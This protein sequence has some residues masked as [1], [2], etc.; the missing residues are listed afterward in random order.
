MSTPRLKLERLEVHHDLRAFA[1]GNVDLDRWLL[2][3]ALAAQQMDSA[4]TFLLMHADRIAGYF[5][6]TM[7]SVV[8]AD[9]PAKLVRGLPDCPIGMV[10]LARLAVDRSKQGKGLGGRL[11]AEALRKAVVAGDAAA[12][13]LVVVDAVDQEAARFYRHHGFIP[14]PE[15][16]L[17]LYRRMKDIRASVDE[18]PDVAG[19]A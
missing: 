5:S 3:H 17:R 4:R 9:A 2:R 11:L 10:L 14:V 6:L 19:S 7:G 18:A 16:P 12:A 15:H 1:S 13:R 8:R